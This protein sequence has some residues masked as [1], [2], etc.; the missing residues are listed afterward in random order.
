MIFDTVYQH[1]E[2]N[3][4]PNLNQSCFRPADSTVNQLLSII[5]SIFQAFDC[6]PTLDVHSV[7]L[8]IAKVFFRDWHEG[9]VCKLHRCGISGKLLLPRLLLLQSFL[10]NRKQ[11]TVLNGKISEWGDIEAG[12]L[13]GSILGPLFF[14]ICINDSTDGLK[15]N[16]KLFAVVHD[17]NTAAVDLNQP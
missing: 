4:L 17:P 13:Q 9:L 12:V 5:N 6:N 14:L 3:S 15:C 10:T 16:L 8:D 2:V 7:Y 11:S 1:L